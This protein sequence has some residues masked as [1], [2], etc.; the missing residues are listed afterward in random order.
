MSSVMT[1]K[2][3]PSASGAAF[4]KMGARRMMWSINN[5]LPKGARWVEYLESTG[6]QW[7]DT[8]IV[9]ADGFGFWMDIYFENAMTTSVP[10]AK[11][12]GS[13][14]RNNGQWGGLI[15]GTYPVTSGGQMTWFDSQKGIF[16][17]PG[18]VSATRM[19]IQSINNTYSTS[20]G[21][22][23]STPF[24]SNTFVYGS[25]YLFSIHSEDAV[26]GAGIRCYGSKIYDGTAVVREFAPIAIGT[27]G[28]MM[29]ILTGE[30]LQYGNKG[31]GNF[32]IGPDAPSPT[33]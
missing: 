30:Y 19:Q 15:L 8:G 23:I 27:T 6:T 9:P 17:N 10:S 21:L 11:I 31:T 25:L 16:Y 28:Y 33:I 32:V 20:R 14:M 22:S 18:L 26:T 13:S 29:D 24:K 5:L 12:L 1:L 7:I 4:G 3:Y 2:R